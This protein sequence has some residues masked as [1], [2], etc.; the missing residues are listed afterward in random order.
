MMIILLTQS[1]YRSSMVDLGTLSLV[2]YAFPEL[3][4][5]HFLFPVSRKKKPKSTLLPSSDWKPAVATKSGFLSSFFAD[6]GQ[7]KHNY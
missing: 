2:S 3:G 1:L 4:V 5:N 6:F 7:A